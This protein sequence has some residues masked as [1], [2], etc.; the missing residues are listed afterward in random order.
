M[1]GSIFLLAKCHGP[2]GHCIRG[3]NEYT[4]E[5]RTI[6]EQFSGVVNE[7]SMDVF[8]MLDSVDE[9]IVEAEE[10]LIDYISTKV[11]GNSLY[12]EVKNNRCLNENR[13]ITVYVK[14]RNLNSIKLSG[15]GNIYCDSVS[16]N[17][18]EVDLTGSGNIEFTSYAPYVDASITG[19]GDI[20]VNG[21]AEET[22]FDITGSGRIQ[23]FNL[24]QEDCFARISGSGNMYVNVTGLLDVS[25]TGSGDVYYIGSPSNVNLS[26][27]GSG[28]VSSF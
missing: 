5:V 27:T 21:V 8:V 6:D 20:I 18:L 22:D 3:N 4:S 23:S 24:E 19:S 9:V 7:G 2:L 28:N 12:I 11:K 16:C 26:V 10:N 15:S 17:A 25:I 1:L 13:D 14:T